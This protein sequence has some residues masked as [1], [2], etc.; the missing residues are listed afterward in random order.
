ML[1]AL[2]RASWSTA[3]VTGRA[4]I[5]MGRP[6]LFIAMRFT[7]RSA[8]RP[9]A[10]PWPGAGGVEGQPHGCPSYKLGYLTSTSGRRERA[11]QSGVVGC[12]AHADGSARTNPKIPT[13]DDVLRAAV[14]GL[15]IA[16][17]QT[18]PHVR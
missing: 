3:T 5:R 17:R 8:H 4:S 12:L 18:G 14:V 15:H 2:P 11:Q 9:V 6:G 16:G 10:D 7:F 1:C 13:A